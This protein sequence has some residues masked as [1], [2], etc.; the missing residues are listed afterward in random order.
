MH[1]DCQNSHNATHFKRI[2][3]IYD[4][5]CELLYS[6]YKSVEVLLTN[7]GAC[8]I[9]ATVAGGSS[10][11]RVVALPRLKRWKQRVVE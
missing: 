6:N 10:P 2:E 11:S 9:I 3:T 8:D 5:R 4:S 7:A 1:S